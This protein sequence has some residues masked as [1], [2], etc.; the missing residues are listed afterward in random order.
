MRALSVASADTLLGASSV[1]FHLIV[2]EYYR[3]Q[4]LQAGSGHPS[5]SVVLGRK[6]YEQVWQWVTDH[7]DVRIYYKGEARNLTLEEFEALERQ[8]TDD[9]V[10]SSQRSAKI[11]STQHVAG[12]DGASQ[13]PKPLASLGA[14]LRQRLQTE[15]N[16]LS[17]TEVP[18]EPS[19][20]SPL[21]HDTAS[22][23]MVREARKVLSSSQLSPPAFEE[24]D[25]SLQV[26]R[27]FVSQ[28]RTWIAITGH[29]I[30]LKKVP[31]SEFILLSIIARAGP[32]GISQPMLQRMSGQDKRSI[33][34]RTNRLQNKGYIDKRP[35]QDGKAR[36][37]LCTHKMFLN[38]RPQEPQSVND[39]FGLRTLNL[40]GLVFLLNKVLES[41]PIVQVR[42][43]RIKMVG[44]ND[45]DLFMNAC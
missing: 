43:L 2:D 30:D 21:N 42:Q 44:S 23:L 17:V 13:P 32:D 11:F 12:D 29:P 20:A 7:P 37:S 28:N 33:P 16:G 45:T 35:I 27:L 19:L 5:S 3:K 26:P 10:A 1:N 9:S 24:P 38:D 14:S 4:N 6:F 31:G 18:L 25:A 34:E 15:A 36:T 39:V 41:T 22:P 40:T 8:G